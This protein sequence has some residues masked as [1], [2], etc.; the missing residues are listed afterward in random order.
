MNYMSNVSEQEW[1]S[2][3][4]QLNELERK[5]VLLMLKTFL[6]RR[7]EDTD[8]TS[9]ELYNKEIDEALAEAAAGNYISQDE[10]EKRAAK[11]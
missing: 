9:I 1:R 5:S 6:Q 8:R 10:I 4:M 2:Y 7:N 3:F 11:W